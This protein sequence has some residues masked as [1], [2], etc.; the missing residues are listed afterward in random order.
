MEVV[1]FYNL[2]IYSY[3]VSKTMDPALGPK[4]SRDGFLHLQSES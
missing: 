3:K 1:K 4:D 2:V